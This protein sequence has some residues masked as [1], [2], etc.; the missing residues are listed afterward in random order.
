MRELTENETQNVSG[1]T[2]DGPHTPHQQAAEQLLL[3]LTGK[4][5]HCESDGN[6][7]QTCKAS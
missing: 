5:H 3:L 4:P 2:G 6:G 7:G 1:G